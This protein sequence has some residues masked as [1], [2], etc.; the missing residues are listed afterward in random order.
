MIYINSEGENVETE[1]M[2]NRYLV[3]AIV[4]AAKEAERYGKF[5]AEMVLEERTEK[6]VKAEANLNVLKAEV[7]NRLDK[8]TN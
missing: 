4:K 1:T 3:N 2:D 5:Q 7:I 6:L 8:K